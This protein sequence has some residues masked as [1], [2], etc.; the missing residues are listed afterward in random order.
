[1]TAARPA[2]PFTYAPMPDAE[3]VL[4][5]RAPEEAAVLIPRL[6]NIGAAAQGAA[7]AAALG[8]AGGSGDAIRAEIVREHGLFLFHHL[9]LA[10]GE[11]RDN[12]GLA[13]LRA[14]DAAAR[15]PRHLF[16]MHFPAALSL[17]DLSPLQLDTLLERGET[18]T[19]RTLARVATFDPAWARADLPDLTLPE[20]EAALAD[21][22]ASPARDATLLTRVRGMPLLAALIARDGPSLLTRLLARVL[23]LCACLAPSSLEVLSGARPHGIGFAQAARG[24]LVHRARVAEGRVMSYKMLAPSRW[25]LAPG[26]LLERMLDALPARAEAGLIARL[27]LLAVNPCVAVR[28]AS[29]LDA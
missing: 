17:A 15:L 16:G 6:Y 14:E 19:T 4:L 2:R 25:T 26:G 13:I 23:D 27:S 1:M 8:L 9:P 20:A 3:R 21:D 29:P 5:G 24:T 7:A 18:A 11:A 10:L 22:T 12:E 28:L